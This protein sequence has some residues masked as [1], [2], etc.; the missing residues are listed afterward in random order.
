[1]PSLERWPQAAGLSR[2]HFHRVFKAVTGVTPKAYAAAHRGK[3]VRAKLARS[4]TV[5]EAIYDAG[6]NSSGRFY[7][8]SAE[9]LGMTPTALPRRRRRHRDPLRGRRVL[10]RRDPGRGDGDGRVRHPARRR[11]R[12]A[13]CAICRT[14]SPRRS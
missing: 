9:L 6:Y 14:A 5:T 8:A 10:A 11:S 1:M 13:A 3:R 4:G 2:F 12:R 7:A